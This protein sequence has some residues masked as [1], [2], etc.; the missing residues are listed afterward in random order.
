MRENIKT[1]KTKKEL[2][3]SIEINTADWKEWET[4]PK[5]F[6]NISKISNSSS[7]DNAGI[8]FWVWIVV[9][10]VIVLVIASL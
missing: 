8:P 9:G 6:Q 3:D 5:E 2:T 1:C 4:T 7:G 10:V